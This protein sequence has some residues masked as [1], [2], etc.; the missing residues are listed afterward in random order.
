MIQPSRREILAA[1]SALAAAP[2]LL[3]CAA[4]SSGSQGTQGVHDDAALRE[5]LA[6]NRTKHPR[7]RGGLANHLSMALC[8]EHALGASDE[9]LAAFAKK[10]SAMLDPMPT[11]GARVDAKHWK[12]ALGHDEA[13]FGL[14]QFFE[15]DLRERGRATALREALDVLTPSLNSAAFHCLIRTAFGVRFDDDA[16]IAHGLAYW[17]VTAETLG[18]LKQIERRESDPRALLERV[19]SDATLAN[20]SIT[21]SSISARMQKASQLQGFAEIAGGLSIDEHSLD[22]MAREMLA[23]FASTGNFTALHAVTST[24]A[25]RVLMPF[26]SDR[27]LSL[28]YHWQALTAAFIGIGS[29]RAKEKLAENTAEWSAIASRAIASDDDHDAK[30]VFACREEQALRGDEMYRFA[31]ALRVKLVS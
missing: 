14:V 24:H 18:A 4:M 25:L 1:G 28:R 5:L 11:S 9:R 16:E 21:G 29:P 22:G 7:Y 20:A 30:L 2:A 31:A 15:N 6:F 26:M 10:Y 19:R 3:A 17:T 23:L 8:A 12:D 13:L 27:E